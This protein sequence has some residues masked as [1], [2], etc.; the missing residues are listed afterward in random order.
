MNLSP[1][2]EF[3]VI[4]ESPSQEYLKTEVQNPPPISAFV[5]EPP[6]EPASFSFDFKEAS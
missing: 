6:E 1:I 5:D 4:L 2:N 3:P